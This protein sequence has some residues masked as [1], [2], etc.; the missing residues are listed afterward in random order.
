MNVPARKHLVVIT[1]LLLFVVASIVFLVVVIERQPRGGSGE[2]VALNPGSDLVSL[3]SQAE[4]NPSG[5]G[6]KPW[7][8]PGRQWRVRVK[9]Y[10]QPPFTSTPVMDYYSK[11][12]KQKPTPPDDFMM[13]VRVLPLRHNGDHDIARFQFIP[14]EDVPKYYLKSAQGA[15]FVL[16]VDAQTGQAVE[17]HPERATR[18]RV[19]SFDDEQYLKTQLWF[20]VDWMLR[21]TDLVAVPAEK[22]Y[23]TPAR[24]ERGE[25]KEFIKSLEAVTVPTRLSNAS[26]K[27]IR[28]VRIEWSRHYLD[29]YRLVQVWV[30]G[31]PWWRSFQRY[32][33]D[34]LDLEATW[35]KDE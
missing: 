8:S 25:P 11:L 4:M 35:V 2:E 3:P 23:T 24:D 19:R 22:R 1:C 13:F 33:G 9:K 14:G 15:K 6:T 34:R 30:P 28:A 7:K 5:L 27:T 32:Y 31:E 10:P 16:E 18:K 26:G 21:N 29:N 20:P 12:A 17:F